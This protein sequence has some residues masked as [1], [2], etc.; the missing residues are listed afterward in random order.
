M[1]KGNKAQYCGKN[2]KSHLP[3]WPHRKS[4]TEREKK[5]IIFLQQESFFIYFFIFMYFF[6]GET[7]VHWVAPVK[8]TNKSINKQKYCW[9]NLAFL[10]IILFYIFIIN[11]LLLF[12][13]LYFYYLF[14]YYC[15]CS[16]VRKKDSYKYYIWASISYL[17]WFQLKLSEEPMRQNKYNYS[18]DE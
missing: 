10:I 1:L 18:L 7:W 13:L 14:Y 4:P 11:N 3:G 9:Q 8:Q 15:F 16:S 17:D 5:N 12:I 2:K 6:D